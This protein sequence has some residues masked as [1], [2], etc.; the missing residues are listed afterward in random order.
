MV[1]L[2]LCAVGAVFLFAACAL[3]RAA[4][5][6][7]GWMGRPARGTDETMKAERRTLS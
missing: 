1:L 5:R 7:F 4:L 6:R 3:A 2:F